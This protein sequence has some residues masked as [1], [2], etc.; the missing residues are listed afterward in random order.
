MEHWVQ[1]SGESCLR[2]FCQKPCMPG[3]MKINFV[4]PKEKKSNRDPMLSENK[5]LFKY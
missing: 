4:S 3:T 1:C 2:F 5:R